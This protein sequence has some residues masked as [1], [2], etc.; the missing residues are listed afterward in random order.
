MMHGSGSAASLPLHVNRTPINTC[1]T[2]CSNDAWIWLCCV[3]SATRES[4]S[5]TPT[6]EEYYRG[7][8][9]A[10]KAVDGVPS[11]GSGGTPTEEEYYRGLIT[12]DKAVD[13]VPSPGSGGTPTEASHGARSTIDRTPAVDPVGT[14]SPL[15][16]PAASHGARSTID[17]T[18]A[19]DPV[20]TSS[21]LGEPA[22][23]H[24]AV[25]G[26]VLSSRTLVA[27][28]RSGCVKFIPRGVAFLEAYC[29]VEPW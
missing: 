26:G 28:A 24:G 12:A 27:C 25:L 1:I 17:R 20:G 11:P 14:S 6:E 23:S 9:T 2:R 19:V 18:P 10:D 16:E 3:A 29:R 4:N 21:P 13:G 15:G 7:L 5:G 22:A 8:I